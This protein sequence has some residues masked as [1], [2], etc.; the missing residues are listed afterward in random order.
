MYGKPD[1]KRLDDMVMQ[2]ARY[3]CEREEELFG[4]TA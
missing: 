3:F 2:T 4:M 1:K